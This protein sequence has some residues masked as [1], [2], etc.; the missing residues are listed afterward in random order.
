MP[1][2]RDSARFGIASY[3][4]RIMATTEDTTHAASP[5]TATRQA[6]KLL[7][8]LAERL[9]AEFT[10]SNVFG[11]PVERDGVTVVPV[12]T[13]RF[14]F[15]GG[16]GADPRKGQDGAGAGAGGIVAAA[17]YIEIK[18]GDSRFVPVVHPARML[19]LISATIVAG[20]LIIR[21][22]SRP[23]RTIALPWR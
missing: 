13:A 10:A 8:A 5:G 4:E 2:A 18:D 3:E 23:R 20:L 9:G 15:G 7:S 22:S 6:E 21:P 12:A 17:G 16:A 1:G 19:A 14:G 11:G